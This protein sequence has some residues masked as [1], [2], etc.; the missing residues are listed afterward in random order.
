MPKAAIA[1]STLTAQDAPVRG[2]HR[3]LDPEPRFKPSIVTQTDAILGC[4][5][6]QVPEGHLA[7][8]VR[9]LVAQLDLKDVEAT[10]SSL[11]RRGYGPREVLAVLL[12]ASLIGVHESTRLARQMETD[13]ALKF[14]TGGYKI[15]GRTLR[16]FRGAH[17]DLYLRGIQETLRIAVKQELLDPEELSVD[18]V[19]F[20]ANASPD[21]VRSLERATVRLKEL[22][23]VDTSSLDAAALADHQEKISRHET[24][25]AE[26]NRRETP[27]Y[28]ETNELAALM[29][30]PGGGALPG[31][32]VTVSSAGKSE[33][34]AVGLL[35]S[36][37]TNDIGLLES[38]M[39]EA[40]RVL[41]EV[42]FPPELKVRARADAGYWSR[43]D[44]L[45]AEANRSWA[46]ILI[47][48]KRAGGKEQKKGF[49]GRDRFKIL[50]NGV[51]CPADKPMRG[52]HR[53][54]TAERWRGVG[55]PECPLKSKCTDTQMRSFFIDRDYE[56][57]ANAMRERMSRPDA[58]GYYVERIATIEP[59]FSNIE[60]VMLY[61]R[62]TARTPTT[63]RAE[64]ALKVLAHNI[65]RLIAGGSHI[66]IILLLDI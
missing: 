54:E 36:A 59:V 64:I 38:A 28:V 35:V 56:R 33:R 3:R 16:R 29:K 23:T 51:L 41:T 40:R 20:R 47:P 57:A 10:Y 22:G 4:L 63:I 65:S 19:R 7:R 11:G 34:F 43:Q 60:S 5:D 37:E 25:V 44:L 9:D 27:N 46:D 39:S 21:K 15:S 62:V 66:F 13:A 50:D 17:L 2:R 45:F 53:D 12:Y 55:C 58:R 6:G 42:G 52:P 18:S 24:T 1:R 14:L 8:K 26:C 49:F 48:E 61:R 31:H 32:R 30:F